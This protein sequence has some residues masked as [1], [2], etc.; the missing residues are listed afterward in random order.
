MFVTISVN[1]QAALFVLL[2]GDKVASEKFHLSLD[3]GA[4]YSTLEG[5][6]D[7]N[8]KLG[9][10]FGLG[11]HLMLSERWYLAPEFKPLSPRGATDLENPIEVPAELNVK[12]SKS[13]LTL[14]YIDVPVLVQHRFPNG[15]YISAG[16]QIS[17][18]TG[19]KQQ[20]EFELDTGTMIDVEEDVKKYFNN[21]DYSF[22]VEIAYALKDKRG[23]KGLDIRARY[24]YGFN[25]LFDDVEGASANASVFQFILT[26]PFVENV[27]SE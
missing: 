5:Y 11:T 8:G 1:A 15:F 12:D 16:P 10:H 7:G 19:A 26:F 22:P 20:T 27:G 25:D 6:E 2:F 9:L 23:G 21:I 13:D 17:F 4:N 24:S 18:L 3:I 14:S